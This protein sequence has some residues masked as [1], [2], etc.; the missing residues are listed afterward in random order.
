MTG[1]TRLFSSKILITLMIFLCSS[2]E[3]ALAQWDRN[4]IGVN[5]KGFPTSIAEI[6][7]DLAVLGPHF[8]YIRTYNSLFDP[9]KAIPSRV[10]S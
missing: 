10:A 5:Y 7:R 6:D 1:K 2:V 8:G 3:P 9:Q 4:Y